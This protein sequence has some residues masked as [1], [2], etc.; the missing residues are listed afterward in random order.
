MERIDKP[1][2]IRVHQRLLHKERLDGIV[3]DFRRRRDV[4]PGCL[5]GC[6]GGIG[7]RFPLHVEGIDF[8]CPAIYLYDDTILPVADAVMRPGEANAGKS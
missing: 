4:D 3:K 8:T 1:R 5:A 6:V 2:T 7:T